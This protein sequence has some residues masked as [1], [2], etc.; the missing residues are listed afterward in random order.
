MDAY[1][2]D[3]K[4]TVL[5][6]SVTLSYQLVH[7]EIFYV[8]VRHCRNVSNR[9]ILLTYQLRRCDDFSAW[10]RTL[11]LITKMDQFLLGTKAVHFSQ[12]SGGSASFK[13]QL[14]RCSNISKV[15]L[16]FSYQLRPL[17]DVLSWS[18]SLSYQLVRCQDVSNWLVLS[19]YQ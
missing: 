17:C 1:S 8:Q 7:H 15:S 18:V 3:F 5:S 9:S 14:L 19:S 4:K 6:W 16:S 13:Y 2:N 12:T 10:F 11:K